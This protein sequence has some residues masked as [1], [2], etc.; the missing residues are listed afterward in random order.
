MNLECVC[1]LC[2]QL[3]N[4]PRLLSC[5]MRVICAEC[6]GSLEFSREDP[7]ILGNSEKRNFYNC[8]F[9]HQESEMPEHELRNNFL[10]SYI[11]SSLEQQNQQGLANGG[12]K[13][14]ANLLC[15]RCLEQILPEKGEDQTP[16]NQLSIEQEVISTACIDCNVFNLC[17]S[18]DEEL[19]SKGSYLSHRRLKNSGLASRRLG[20]GLDRIPVKCSSHQ[21]QIEY[22]DIR[23]ER[24]LC[25]ECLPSYKSTGG[26]GAQVMTIREGFQELAQQLLRKSER[27]GLQK[28]L[29]EQDKEFF[30][31][32]AE[33]LEAAYEGHRRAVQ[34]QFMQLKD[35]L[36]FKEKE[37]YIT[38]DRLKERA[39]AKVSGELTTLDD[40][41][42]KA[43]AAAQMTNFLLVN[44]SDHSLIDGHKYL[45][46]KLDSLLGSTT[47]RENSNL[48]FLPAAPS[49]LYLDECK[50]VANR[51]TVTESKPFVKGNSFK[52]SKSNRS[53]TPKTIGT[54]AFDSQRDNGMV[55]EWPRTQMTENDEEEMKD[56]SAMISS[57]VRVM[58]DLRS[59]T[60]SDV[61]AGG[62][63]KRSSVGT[64][65]NASSSNHTRGPSPHFEKKPSGDLSAHK[66]GRE[67]GS[68]ANAGKKGAP[69]MIVNLSNVRGKDS[70]VDTSNSKFDSSRQHHRADSKVL[71]DE[72]LS[73]QDIGHIS[74]IQR[75]PLTKRQ[76][77]K[78]LIGSSSL[79]VI[80][81]ITM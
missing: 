42:G 27:L 24:F 59:S 33:Q 7:G 44:V 68:P 6:L 54:P 65:L 78:K 29:A 64:P 71:V 45:N 49:L 5:C 70:L 72:A 26:K 79:Y 19:H 41:M 36:N 60:M 48:R 11:S 81:G 25:A 76:F 17:T 34:H 21:G 51:I 53:E 47:R 57:K 32:L 37:A 9:C 50:H 18:C 23:T 80:Q 43:T 75:N 35:I 58:D 39:L 73:N 55:A 12:S 77:T 56:R 62:G 4:D 61:G 30:G 63:A 2:H 16:S 28:S 31:T 38:L 69:R 67:L 10:T 15:Q 20:A 8:C 74:E 3:I 14:E 52:K 40:F 66:S 46:N 1:P 22:I 13:F